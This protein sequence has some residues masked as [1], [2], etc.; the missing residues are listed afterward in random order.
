M[1]QR[2]R[3]YSKLSLEPRKRAGR[4]E[5]AK[6]TLGTHTQNLINVMPKNM[7]FQICILN[8][9]RLLSVK[10]KNESNCYV[11]RAELHIALEY[12]MGDAARGTIIL[13]Q[14]KMASKGLFPCS[15]S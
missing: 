7:N 9:R 6:K 12:C 4:N 15:H 14:N 1:G 10:Q 13:A 8:L 11:S 5:I 2:K 3:N